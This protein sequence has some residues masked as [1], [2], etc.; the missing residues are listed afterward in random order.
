MKQR[1]IEGS[2]SPHANF[3]GFCNVID[4]PE[5]SYEFFSKCSLHKLW[6]KDIST[7]GARE[8][9]GSGFVLASGAKILNIIQFSDSNGRLKDPGHSHF[10]PC[11]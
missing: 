11:S 7:S 9:G 2:G 4:V 10:V 5:N 6:N 8:E 3:G 1:C